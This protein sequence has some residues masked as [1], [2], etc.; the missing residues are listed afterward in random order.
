MDHRPTARDVHIA[1]VAGRAAVLE[2]DLA[3]VRGEL[4]EL[5]A[6]LAETRAAIGLI[7]DYLREADFDARL[8]AWRWEGTDD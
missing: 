6:T 2:R 4:A 8:N 3:T 5:G 1:D 7:A